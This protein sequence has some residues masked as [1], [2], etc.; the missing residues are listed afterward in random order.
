M[1]L[2]K[3]ILRTCLNSRS[4]EEARQAPQDCADPQIIK[5]R[6]NKPHSYVFKFVNLTVVIYICILFLT[7]SLNY[8]LTAGKMMSRKPITRCSMRAP[9]L[10]EAETSEGSSPGIARQLGYT[11]RVDPVIKNSTKKDFV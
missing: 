5:T 9:K 1:V 7:R 10:K 8:V 6:L 11:P 4:S 3:F 2:K